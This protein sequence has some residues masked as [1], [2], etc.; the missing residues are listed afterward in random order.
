[1]MQEDFFNLIPLDFFTPN[2][3]DGIHHLF[4]L[5]KR[6]ESHSRNMQISY[7]YGSL[8]SFSL[9]SKIESKYFPLEIQN[10]VS[11]NSKGITKLNLK[12]RERTISIYFF[13]IN[14]DQQIQ[15]KKYIKPLKLW[16]SLMD[17]I[18][19]NFHINKKLKINIY[20]TPFKKCMPSMDGEF[21]SH[22]INSALTNIC[23]PEGEITIYRKEEWFKVLL[24]E[25][26]HSFCLDFSNNTAIDLRKCLFNYFPIHVENVLYSESYAETWAEI[27]NCAIISFD[28]VGDNLRLFSLYFNYYMQVEIVHSIFQANKIL[29]RYNSSFK[30]LREKKFLWK[31]KTHVFEYHIIKTI[32]L[33]SFDKFIVW[34]YQNNGYNLIP[35]NLEN[36]WSFCNLIKESYEKKELHEKVK[37]IKMRSNGNSLRMSINEI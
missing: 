8:Q 24:H 37:K 22:H 14:N 19:P 29:D 2:K 11:K 32:L 4:K 21:T 5:L 26:I 3:T 31:Q 13:S 28:D 16:F 35:F 17:L 20:L 33:F 34:C 1:M 23:L 10:Y 7:A 27:L 25:C 30:T 36:L 18:T 9:R 6:A 15:L 12:I